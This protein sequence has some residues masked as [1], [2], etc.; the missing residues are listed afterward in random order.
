MAELKVITSNTIYVVHNYV[1]TTPPQDEYASKLAETLER[2][3]KIEEETIPQ[4]ER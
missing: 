1:V 2:V 3:R 4:T